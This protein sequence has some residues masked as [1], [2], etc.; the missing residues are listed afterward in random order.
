MGEPQLSN[1]GVRRLFATLVDLLHSR[2]DWDGYVLAKYLD[3]SGW[4]PDAA[5][6]EVLHDSARLQYIAIRE[7]AIRWV[8][9][10]KLELTNQA[11][12]LVRFRLHTHDPVLEGTVQITY[13]DTYELGVGF[14]SG[15]VVVIPQEYVI[16]P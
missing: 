11:G 4:D 13:P 7:E 9:E 1:R 10:E 14:P 12:D 15:Q 3:E 6:V 2:E 16:T 8:H 5:L